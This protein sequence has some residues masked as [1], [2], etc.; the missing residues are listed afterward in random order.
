VQEWISVAL[1]ASGF[2]V[3]IWLRPCALRVNAIFVPSGDQK[4]WCQQYGFEE[5]PTDP[6]H[7]MLLLK[8]I[9]RFV[10]SL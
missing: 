7:V 9:R 10:D 1:L 2:M 5:P 8:D 6:L 4:R 3:Q